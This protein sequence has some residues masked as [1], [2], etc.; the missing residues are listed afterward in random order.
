MYYS[1]GSRPSGKEGGGGGGGHQ[2]LEKGGPGPGLKNFFGPLGL[3]LRSI[4]SVWSKN[5]EGPWAPPW[6]CHCIIH[7][8]IKINNNR[9]SGI[10]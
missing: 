10:V 2:T 6:I 4:A 8:V 7:M 1:G 3:S 9:H 5:N